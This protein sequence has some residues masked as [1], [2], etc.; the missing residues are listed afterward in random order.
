MTATRHGRWGSVK[1]VAPAAVCLLALTA[2][3]MTLTALAVQPPND[4]SADASWPTLAP[5]PDP[6]VAV[7]IGDSYSSG[8]GASEM[9]KRWTTRLSATEGWREVNVAHPGTG[10]LTTAGL[11]VCGREF[12][13]NYQGAVAEAIKNKAQ[14]VVVAGGQNDQLQDPSAEQAAIAKV[15]R[16]LRAGLPDAQ[17]IAVG[18]STP[19]AEPGKNLLG[20][21]AAVQT[22]AAQNEAVYVSL[23]APPAIGPGM[24]LADS[25]AAGD[26]VH[27]AI[28]QRVAAA[29][30]K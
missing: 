29:V 25:A 14:I 13:P 19:D 16:D 20:I 28:E 10:Y 4:T 9:S 24:V 6:P 30:S 7:F 18:P 2:L 3:V 17:I 8:V 1:Y 22:A 27:A 23:L 21:D 12:C 5:H 26:A 15:Y 11:Q